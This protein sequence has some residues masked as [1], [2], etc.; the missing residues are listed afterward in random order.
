[1]TVNVVRMDIDGCNCWPRCL[2]WLLHPKS[3]NFPETSSLLCSK[4]LTYKYHC[5]I[6]SS[7]SV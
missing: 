7:I 2:I 5:A 6:M 4:K 3:P 1:M